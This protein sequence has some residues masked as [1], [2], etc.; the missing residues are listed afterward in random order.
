MPEIEPQSP[1]HL[2][3]HIEILQFSSDSFKFFSY[4]I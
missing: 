4:N 1:G 3:I 2:E